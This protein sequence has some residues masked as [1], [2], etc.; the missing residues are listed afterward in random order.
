MLVRGTPEL[1]DKDRRKDIEMN[2]QFISI[3]EKPLLIV[4]VGCGLH[5]RVPQLKPLP[6]A[7]HRHHQ[8]YSDGRCGGDGA[9]CS[10]FC[11]PNAKEG[12][13]KKSPPKT[14]LAYTR[15]SRNPQPSHDAV[16]RAATD[17]LIECGGVEVA[18]RPNASVASEITC[19]GTLDMFTKSSPPFPRG[20]R[21]ITPTHF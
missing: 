17:T 16:H 19:D 11:V 13:G 2:I 6:D 12:S 14:S 5:A 4:L 15:Y 21:R 3:S 18:R 10:I 9:G 20:G 7:G 1:D 8:R